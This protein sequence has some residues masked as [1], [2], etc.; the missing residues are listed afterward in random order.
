MEGGVG[1]RR[2]QGNGDNGHAKHRPSTAISPVRQSASVAA[3]AALA[4][5]YSG[6]D[7]RDDSSA[8]TCSTA[9]G[10]FGLMKLGGGLR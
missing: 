9:S 5:S 3:A 10:L 1:E 8:C 4:G 6:T 2:M 7:I